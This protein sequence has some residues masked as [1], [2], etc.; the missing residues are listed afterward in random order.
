MHLD[1]KH[2]VKFLHEMVDDENPRIRAAA[3]AAL[4][5]LRGQGIHA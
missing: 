1:P 5:R 4:E 3:D 2:S